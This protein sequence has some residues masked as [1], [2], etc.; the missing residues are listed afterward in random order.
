MHKEYSY[1][2]IEQYLSGDLPEKDQMQ[3]EEQLQTDASLKQKVLICQS[4][5]NLILLNKLKDLKAIMS[6]EQRKAEQPKFPF[7]KTGLA[8]LIS[9][10]L[11]SGLAIYM[12]KNKATPANTHKKI[13][14]VNQ[15]AP[16]SEGTPIN[17]DQL[18]RRNNTVVD[19]QKRTDT[20]SNTDTTS[21]PTTIV[22]STPATIVVQDKL[23]PENKTQ[24]TDLNQTNN[25]S[26]HTPATTAVINCTGVDI[27]ADISVTE[28]CFGSNNGSIELHH[29]HGGKAPY[30]SILNGNVT[31]SGHTFKNLYQGNYVIE[32]ADANGCK[33]QFN[34]LIL[35]GKNCVTN[36]DFNT[37]LGE[38]WA[39]PIA[40]QS[41]TLR[42][43]DK[44]GTL[45]YTKQLMPDEQC[46]WT[47]H[48][49]TG[50]LLHGYFVF[51]LEN[52]DGSVNRGSI[53]ITE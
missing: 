19:S 21:K 26:I 8:I 14:P 28:P 33:H 15:A 31:A 49:L 2:E 6:E 42:I 43:V 22:S 36:Y 9:S 37:S 10:V 34:T 45:V 52:K 11:I 4:A 1:E 5:P 41:C 39:G 23:V 17:A 30:K 27:A 47:G 50:G 24:K 16:T 48:S 32:V 18:Q 7:N 12:N 13:I 40:D 20:N 3:F 46:T 51:T 38:S 29:L 25:T 35:V 44:N 53:T